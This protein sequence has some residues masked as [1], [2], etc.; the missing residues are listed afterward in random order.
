MSLYKK[1]FTCESLYTRYLLIKH[2]NVASSIERSG[3]TYNISSHI[4]SS[5]SCYLVIIKYWNGGQYVFTPKLFSETAWPIYF[6]FN[7]S[8]FETLWKYKWF[9][10][11]LHFPFMLTKID[12]IHKHRQKHTQNI[13]L[14]ITIYGET[15]VYSNENLRR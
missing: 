8:A 11:I 5:T 10:F 4:V 15:A 1:Y 13:A 7:T 2:G 12:A 14:M 9:F 3:S 6:T